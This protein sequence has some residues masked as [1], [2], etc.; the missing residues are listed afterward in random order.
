MNTWPPCVSVTTGTQAIE[1]P[2]ITTMNTLIK[3]V[4]SFSKL[5]LKVSSLSELNNACVRR[6]FVPNKSQRTVRQ[7]LMFTNLKSGVRVK[8]RN[9]EGVV[10][11]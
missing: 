9:Y 7:V 10:I 4:K 5:K 3:T 2:T 1:T 11:F 6:V 8:L